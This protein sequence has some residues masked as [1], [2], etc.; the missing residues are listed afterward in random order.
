MNLGLDSSST[1]IRKISR[2]FCDS[3][4]G[5]AK[6]TLANIETDPWLDPVDRVRFSGRIG[7][8]FA[9]IDENGIPV[10]IRHRSKKRGYRPGRVASYALACWN[11]HRQTGDELYRIVFLK[12][13]EWFMQFDGG[14]F[15]NDF[16]TG[17]L[18][19]PWISGLSQSLGISVLVRAYL[20]TQDDRF[21]V[22]SRK[23]L[24][25]MLVPIE[26]GGVASR[27]ADGS[28]FIEEYPINDPRHVLNGFLS[29]V[30]G[31]IDLH[32]VDPSQRTKVAV[33]DCWATLNANIVHWNLDGWSAYDLHNYQHNG[34]RNF[35][36]ASYHSLHIVQLRYA[37]TQTGNR[38]FQE[39]SSQWRHNLEITSRR[40][41]AHFAK[42]HYRIRG[43]SG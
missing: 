37:L 9:P 13:A 2:D 23:A 1:G 34:L 29:A 24:R 4:S 18:N 40:M 25:P 31:I 32:R 33:D 12:C 21:L 20:L 19:A 22:Q 7:T 35:A 15:L 17:A 10:V 27:L 30:F 14:R 38:R 28:F 41:H 42:I 39:L 6:Y 36:T 16:G 11:T 3:L 43:A 8:S 5:K 26:K